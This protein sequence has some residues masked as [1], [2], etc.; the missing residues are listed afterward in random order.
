[1]AAGASSGTYRETCR[2]DPSRDTEG[3]AKYVPVLLGQRLQVRI[4]GRG[5]TGRS[6]RPGATHDGPAPPVVRVH[7]APYEYFDPHRLL[8]KAELDPRVAQDLV[9]RAPHDLGAWAIERIRIEFIER[10]D[11]T[12]ERPQG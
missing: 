3:V 1:V 5:E 10:A 2:G 11:D 6:R 4:S 7:K 12:A 8:S 9:T